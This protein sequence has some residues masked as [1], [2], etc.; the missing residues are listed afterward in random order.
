MMQS[1]TSESSI[2]LLVSCVLSH[3][4]HEISLNQ[5]DHF[6]FVLF[7]PLACSKFQHCS[8]AS[9]SAMFDWSILMPVKH[10]NKY[11]DFEVMLPNGQEN[12]LGSAEGELLYKPLENR[13]EFLSFIAVLYAPGLS[14]P[15]RLAEPQHSCEKASDCRMAPKKDAWE[16]PW[17]AWGRMAFQNATG[18]CPRQL[19][20]WH[21]EE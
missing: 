10:R 12:K 18:A 16:M 5:V 21:P 20:C 2:K 8:R 3:T 7:N 6:C 14:T 13:K 15:G 11:R 9:V 19:L 17:K 4:L 1:I